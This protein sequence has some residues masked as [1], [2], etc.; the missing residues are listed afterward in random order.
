MNV[1]RRLFRPNIA[2]LKENRD[3]GKLRSVVASG[4]ASELRVEAVEALAA[5]AD[6]PARTALVEAFVTG[7][8]EVSQ[9]AETALRNLG[10]EAAEQLAGAVGTAVGGR[11]VDALLDL[12]AAALEPLRSATGA[13]DEK[14]R[15]Q[16]LDGLLEL[17]RR[18]CGQEDVRE[19]V[20]RTL[21][22]SLGDR[23]PACRARAASGLEAMGD[24]RAGRALAAQLKDRDEAVRGACRKAL[25]ALGA[26]AV[27]HLVGALRDRN[28]NSRRLAAELLGETCSPA[29]AVDVRLEALAALVER[30]RDGN[31][32]IREAV[33][34]ALQRIP[35]GDAVASQLALLADPERGDRDATLE[36]VKGL[37]EHA[38]A[39][40]GQRAAAIRRIRDLGFLREADDL[41]G[42]LG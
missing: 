32:E 39:D 34:R 23:S 37:L 1:L 38:V 5:L 2:K 7:G 35:A 6:E 10:P 8:D 15:L 24:G 29:A 26:T 28:P 30:A 21:L 19:P 11:A 9:A 18:L 33:G 22:A 25:A 13:A 14:T 40:P 20:F 36:L 27:P 41:S 3:L 16:A 42:R 17:D 12:G 4:A 31:A